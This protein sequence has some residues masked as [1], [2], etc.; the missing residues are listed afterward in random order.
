MNTSTSLILKLITVA[1]IACVPLSGESFY[2][3]LVAKMLLMAIFAMSLDL[4][5][6]FTGLVSFGH[7]AYFGI[8]AYS[9]ALFTAQFG[10]MS[11]WLMLPAAI[12]LSAT[13]AL[14]IGFFAIRT[15]GIYFIMV[16][17]AFAQM[18]YFVF[19]DT[20]LG[21][22]SDG[23]FVDARPSAAIAGWVPFDLD[24]EFHLFYFVLAMMLLVYLFLQRVLQ[25]PFGR[26]LMGIKSNEHRMQSL[27]YFT[28]GYKLAAFALAGG[29]GGIAGFLYA[30]L[31][32]F[33]TPELLSWHES[34][35]VLLM[36]ILG[37]MGN[38]AGAVLGAFAFEAMR[39]F[40]ADIT[41]YWQLLMGGVIVA[42]VLFLPG[43]LTAIPGRIKR[44]LQGGAA[45]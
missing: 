22:G 23:V 1:A 4:L 30:V 21:G 20:P 33:V 25:S 42:L 34:G 40:F 45:K 12:L 19:H 17:L 24:N 36:V 2:I 8:A 15:K 38:L 44:A 31:F 43:G 35:N 13:A 41:K 11:L 16:T 5:V 18:A 10:Q 26:V 9:V 7:A 39:E 14:V 28:F 3:E 32:G 37:G 27:G 6:G 29:L